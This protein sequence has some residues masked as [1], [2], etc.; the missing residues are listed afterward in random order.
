MVKIRM[1][2]TGGKNEV[3]YRLVAADNNTPRD[4]RVLET[5]G[6][7]DPKRE[8]VNFRIRV[9]RIEHWMGLG[10][11]ASATVRSLLGKARRLAREAQAE[12]AAQAAKA[13]QAAAEQPAAAAPAPPEPAAQA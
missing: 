2:R 11:Q 3:S 12:Q 8:G 13:A 5:L 9:D 6:W 4:G 7:Y 1:T 10:A